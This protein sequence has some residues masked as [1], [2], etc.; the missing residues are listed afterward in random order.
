[1]IW[2]QVDRCPETDCIP[3]SG[4]LDKFLGGAF[5]FAVI[6]HIIYCIISRKIGGLTI[7]FMLTAAVSG[8][9]GLLL[10]IKFDERSIPILI[11][12]FVCYKV[13]SY[14]MNKK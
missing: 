13:A 10:A 6:S 7:Y 3:S 4:S 1:M 8:G 14:L 12:A 5:T 2:A 9:M 11:F